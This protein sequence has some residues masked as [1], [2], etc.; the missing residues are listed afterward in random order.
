MKQ[1]LEESS[2]DNQRDF[3]IDPTARNWTN[4]FHSVNILILFSIQLHL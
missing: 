1:N 3:S 2:E 4:E